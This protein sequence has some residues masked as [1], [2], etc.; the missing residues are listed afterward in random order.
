[1]L[2]T[3]VKQESTMKK[4]ILILSLIM[5]LTCCKEFSGSKREKKPNVIVFLSDDQ[6]WGDLSMN[7][8]PD[9]NTPHIDKLAK[10]GAVFQNFYVSPVCAPTRA[11]MLT[12][13]YHLRAGV[14]GVSSGKERMDLDE[15]TLAEIFK[16][17]GYKTGA[18]GKWHNG[19]QY[20]YHPNGR[21]FDEF[22]GFCSGHW[23][24]YFSPMLERNGQI[25]KG[26]GFVID[27]FTS[28]AIKFIEENKDSP[29]FVYLPYNTPHSPMQVPDKWWDKF[30]D[31]NITTEN[32]YRKKE[33]IEMTRAAYALCENID[34]NVGR[35]L[36]KL[37][38]LGLDDNTIII[39]FSDNG[40]NS[41]RWNGGMK[42]KKGHVDEG[43]VR[44]PFI[45]NW[46]NNIA[47]EQIIEQIA[48]A[49]D[50]LPT[51]LDL[52]SISYE[53]AKKLDGKSLK[54][55]LTNSASDWQDRYIVSYW[56]SNVS[57][58]N[59]K[60][61]LDNE[62]RLYDMD[63][64][65]G[66]L[67]DISNNMPELLSK[68]KDYKNRWNK[69]IFSELEQSGKR[70]FSIG[71][72]D[73]NCFQLPVRD[74]VAHGTIQRSNQFPNCSYVTNWRSTNDS[75]TWDV[76]I[77]KEGTYS[78]TLYYTCSADNMG[79]TI[80]LSFNGSSLQAQV[81]KAHDSPFLNKE[82]D[83]VERMESY[84]KDF[85]PFTMGN[86]YLELGKGP[87]V[88]KASEVSGEQVMDFRL[89]MLDRV[90]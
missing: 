65:P 36:N 74:A 6:G 82:F 71:H 89:L 27:D 66:Q 63:A 3:T 13:R 51:L 52:T 9:L 69:E 73:Y 59:Q 47:K 8:N 37:D 31:K 21:G 45:I 18:F 53:P 49:I 55:L 29:F 48:G 34:W 79:S 12:G 25:T 88:L 41:W 68:M 58:R 10:D 30:K 86:I 5:L 22:Y 26:K 62:N 1:M 2:D 61:R 90:E 40:P 24:N 14:T 56:N 77:L 32:R 72:P 54:P 17:N 16:Q 33:N 4:F 57:L 44:S 83:R 35:I 84:V 64:D 70:S 23:G 60:Y 67:N 76:E 28:E 42:G 80:E 7:G 78:A 15:T 38:E 85:V 81:D 43:G 50:I 20:P 39:Y 19:M 75:I 11:E 46:K 87:L